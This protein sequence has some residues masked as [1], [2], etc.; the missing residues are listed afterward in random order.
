MTRARMSAFV[1]ASG[2]AF[3]FLAAMAVV[4]LT[5][6]VANAAPKSK[7]KSD[8]PNVSGKVAVFGFK[9]EG[10]EHVQQAVVSALRTRGLEVTT[11]LRPVDTAEQFRDMAATLQLAAYIEGSVGGNGS[12]GQATVHV[13]SGVTGR[14]IA[15]IRFSADRGALAGG[16]LVSDLDDC[17]G[18]L[19]QLALGR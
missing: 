6:S 13:R 1:R 9:G 11:S 5:G 18:L 15:S 16:A 17:G 7:T 14:R 19:N 8:G 12:R 4:V 10:A 3:T 2:R